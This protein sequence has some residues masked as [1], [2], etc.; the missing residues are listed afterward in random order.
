MSAQ[1]LA[2]RARIV[3]A[4]AGPQVPPI[5]EVARNLGV[6]ADTVRKWRRRFRTLELC[7]SRCWADR[8][9]AGRPHRP[10]SSH[11]RGRT[12]Q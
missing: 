3:L 10:T 11:F 7:G 8:T 5:V 9:T 6:A 2:L 4:C 1:S 12:P